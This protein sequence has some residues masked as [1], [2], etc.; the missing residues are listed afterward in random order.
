MSYNIR[1]HW[2]IFP[3]CFY[4]AKSRE[5]INLSKEPFK[6]AVNVIDG[7]KQAGLLGSSLNQ[8]RQFAKICLELIEVIVV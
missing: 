3:G 2:E 7:K 4:K 5:T 1:S 6:Q 8:S